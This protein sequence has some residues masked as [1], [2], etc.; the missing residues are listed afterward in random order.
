M[1]KKSEEPLKKLSQINPNSLDGLVLEGMLLKLLE[2]NQSPLNAIQIADR[3]D[4]E[5]NA[6]NYRLIDRALNQLI[7]QGTVRRYAIEQQSHWIAIYYDDV[8][9]ADIGR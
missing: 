1:S 7:E 9:N 4:V 3:L 8:D 6:N 5:F 2:S